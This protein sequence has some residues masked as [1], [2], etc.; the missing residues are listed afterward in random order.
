MDEFKLDTAEDIKKLE[1]LEKNESLEYR[2]V[3]LPKLIEMQLLVEKFP[4]KY[5]PFN[6]RSNDLLMLLERI[7]GML[8]SRFNAELK[9]FSPQQV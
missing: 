7:C 5:I 8:E 6:D 4:H 1:A 3:M 9:Y 2:K